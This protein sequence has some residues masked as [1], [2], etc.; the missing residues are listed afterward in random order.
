MLTVENISFAY[1]DKKTINNISFCLKEGEN[2][3]VIGESGSGKSTLLQLLYGLFDLTQGKI[4]WQQQAVLGPKHH[5]I[6]GMPDMK[7]LAQDFGLMPYITVAENVGLFLSNT[8]IVE[9]RARIFELLEL[10][11]MVDFGATKVQFL[12]GGQQQRVA[13]AKVLALKPKLLLLDEPFSNIDCFRKNELRRQ[14]FLYLK[15]H[16]IASIVAT[17]D[18]VD[19]LS[20]SDQ[21]M[22]LREGQIVQ[23]GC[24]KS[25]FQ[26]PK[27]QYVASLFGEVNLL[28]NSDLNIFE[29]PKKAILVYAHQ[30]VLTHFSAIKAVITGHYFK[31]NGYL[32][33]AIFDGKT[34][35]FENANPIK[36]G[37]IVFLK[38]K[39]I[40]IKVD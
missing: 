12:S 37:D 30:L 11:D 17:H 13:L 19:A 26:N 36:A 16:D 23:M 2:L 32:L 31:G 3:A 10:V 1:F 25:V 18:R 35:F 39:E 9:K 40:C 15:K 28:K 34:I 22:V 6:P 27:T 4:F 20:F 5:L 7:Y 24:S 38:L 14:L 29:N 8:D 21:I 33:S